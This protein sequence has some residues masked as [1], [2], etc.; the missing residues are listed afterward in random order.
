M[1]L[2]SCYK[3]VHTTH[4]EQKLPERE[5]ERKPGRERP[6]RRVRAGRITR[7]AD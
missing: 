4:F 2:F 3:A 1:R 7:S 5:P 6:A